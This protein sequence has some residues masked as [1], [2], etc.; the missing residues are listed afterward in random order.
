MKYMQ[1]YSQGPKREVKT[2]RTLVCSL[3]VLHYTVTVF[4]LSLCALN[5]VR[6]SWKVFHMFSYVMF[7]S[8]VISFWCK[9]FGKWTICC[10]NGGCNGNFPTTGT[11]LIIGRV[12]K[13]EMEIYTIVFCTLIIPF[14]ILQWVYQTG[15]DFTCYY[16]PLMEP[17]D[18][19][20]FE[21]LR[22]WYGYS[23]STV[24]GYMLGL[25]TSTF[26]YERAELI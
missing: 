26:I 3:N 17:L 16:N 1:C 4:C 15:N 9:A 19:V 20:F 22:E 25:L 2:M 11:Y 7:E 12:F 10:C 18:S 23:F 6:F 14:N 24:I 13:T 21:Y 5:I 8:F